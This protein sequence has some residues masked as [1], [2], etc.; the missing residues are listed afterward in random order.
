MQTQY[1]D[2]DGRVV[3][4]SPPALESLSLLV[5]S[6]I[7]QQITTAHKFPRSIKRF[8]DETLQMVTL[9]ETIADQCF[10][11]LPRSGKN[12]EG[13][14]ARFAEVIL[15]SWGNCRAG[16]RIVEETAEFVVAQGAYHDLERNVGI[17]YE[18]RRRITDKNNKRFNAD[19]IGVTAN[20]ACSIAFR[21]AIL[22]GVPKAFWED[23][24]IAARQTAM[25]DIKTLANRRADA[26]A[27]F[28]KYGVSLD[29]I[30]LKLDLVGKGIEDVG[31]EHLLTLRGILTAIREGDTTPEDAFSGNRPGL[32]AAAASVK[33]SPERDALMTRLRQAGQDGGLDAVSALWTEMSEDD[34][35]LVGLG[36]EEIK[37]GVK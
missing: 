30:L 4:D 34:R 29:Q 32:S 9:S 33:S 28:Q 16:A 20:A 7:E 23:M 3:S 36:I 26:V 1:D 22:K 13:P 8:R 37:A 11:V 17:T 27:T 25:G 18:T 21:N 31:L 6:E 12:I 10:Y 5:R 35:G 2:D 19:M 15:N 14:S 24:Y